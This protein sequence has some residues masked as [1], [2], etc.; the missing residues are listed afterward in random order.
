[1]LRAMGVISRSEYEDLAE[2]FGQPVLPEHA[3]SPEEEMQQI[4]GRRR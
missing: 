4:F 1:M 3:L 2:G